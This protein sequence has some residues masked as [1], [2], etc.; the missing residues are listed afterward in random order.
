MHPAP[1]AGRPRRRASPRRP[2]PQS[3]AAAPRTSA[4]PTLPLVLGPAETRRTPATQAIRDAE[5]PAL[6]ITSDPTLWEETKDARAKLG[7]VLVYDPTHLCDTPARLHWSPTSNCEDKDTGGPP[8]HRPA[9]RHK[10]SAKLDRRRRHR[11]DP[12]P[13]LPARRSGGRPPHQ[14]RTP[15]GPGHPG[16]GG[17]TD[18]SYAPESR[19]GSA[20]ELEAAL[21]AYP[22]RR[23][24]AQELTARA[25]S[26]LFT[27]NIREAC[28]PNRTDALTLDSF[29]DEGGTLFVV[30]EAIEDPKSPKAPARCRFS[31]HSPQAWSSTAGAWPNGHPPVGSTHQ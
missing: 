16:P 2:A 8:G 15:L 19:L 7:P 22:E 12:P 4:T 20:G 10:A 27:V 17:G 13:Q 25:L 29:V 31:R 11:R 23:D 9:G 26:A 30:G 18:P 24:M 5:G 28:T 21:T 6:I 3:R 1:H 14:A